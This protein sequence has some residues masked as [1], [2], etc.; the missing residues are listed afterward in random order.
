MR[1]QVSFFYFLSPFSDAYSN[2][3]GESTG[4]N[5]WLEATILTSPSSSSPSLPN[6]D[7]LKYPETLPTPLTL[8]HP[9]SWYIQSNKCMASENV[10]DLT[11]DSDG[12]ESTTP[13]SDAGP[14]GTGR[15]FVDLLKS[16]D[17]VGVMCRDLVSL[18]SFF[19]TKTKTADP[20]LFIVQRMGELYIHSQG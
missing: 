13:G 15:G 18:S 8:K 1:R 5:S 4:A 16:G 11:W 6:D 19:C 14:E 10:Y 17:R 9:K 20:T 7:H 3:T 12:L 2:L